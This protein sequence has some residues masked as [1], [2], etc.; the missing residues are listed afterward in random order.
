LLCFEFVV[1]SCVGS[2][3]ILCAVGGE[4][5]GC[6]SAERGPN[7]SLHLTAMKFAVSRSI[8]AVV[9]AGEFGRSALSN[10]GQIVGIGGCVAGS[11]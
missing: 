1:V 10:I 8:N 2:W 6:Q 3:F 7:Q 9:A 5:C 11:S 4:K